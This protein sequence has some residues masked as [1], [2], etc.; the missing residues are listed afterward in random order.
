MSRRE[1]K[2]NKAKFSNFLQR[3]SI[4]IV[5]IVMFLICSIL[6]PYFFTVNNLINVAR[7]LCVGVLLAYA[8]MILIV[9]GFLD[10]SIGSVLALSGVMACSVYKATQSMILALVV[11]LAVGVACNLINA[12]FVAEFNVPAFIA[13]LGMQQM[14]RGIALYYTNGANIL[15]I[16]KF[17]NIGQGMVGPIPVPVLIV[18]VITITSIPVS[19][20]NI[21]IMIPIAK[22]DISG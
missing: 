21:P 4:F 2:M 17:V 14:A 9:S 22:S 20:R 19:I 13:T 18:A 3:F 11:A 10:L 5:L 7:Q 12:L 1:C 16:G 15:Q 8:E 6:S